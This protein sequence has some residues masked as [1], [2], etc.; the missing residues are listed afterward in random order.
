MV[1]AW[2]YID[3]VF[4]SINAFYLCFFS[5]QV[6]E[7]WPLFFICPSFTPGA[8]REFSQRDPRNMLLP[9]GRDVSQ[10]CL[11][12]QL[13]L[14]SPGLYEESVLQHWDHVSQRNKFVGPNTLTRVHRY[15]SC[16]RLDLNLQNMQEV[17]HMDLWICK[18]IMCENLDWPLWITETRSHHRWKRT[19][20]PHLPWA[21]EIWF[22]GLKE[23][24]RCLSHL[25]PSPRRCLD[26][27]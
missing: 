16:E 20:C 18:C 5:E 14:C 26:G 9:G 8:P 22:K 17:D 13:S 19:T 10:P 23:Q 3:C 27:V 4:M 24:Q 7:G 11:A 1:W 2:S 12:H 15:S 6:A 21:Q 25:D